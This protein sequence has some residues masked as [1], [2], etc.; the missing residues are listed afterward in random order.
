MNNKTAPNELIAKQ[1]L[2]RLALVYASNLSDDP[3]R[4]TSIEELKI[5][6]KKTK[7][8]HFLGTEEKSYL[9]SPPRK[10]LDKRYSWFEEQVGVF[11]WALGFPFAINNYSKQIQISSDCIF[12]DFAFLADDPVQRICEKSTIVD[13]HL[14]SEGR[15]FYLRYSS[16]LQ[17]TLSVQA[18]LILNSTTPLFFS[19][20]SSEAIRLSNL[21]KP[22]KVK[23]EMLSIASERYV[24]FSWLLENY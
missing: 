3:E 24:A 16:I 19:L 1:L 23:Q 7:L 12:D 10:E 5:W 14:V 6:L 18:S 17:G 15:N 13:R 2:T 4:E 11:G 20:D 21:P 9:N 8:E 22:N